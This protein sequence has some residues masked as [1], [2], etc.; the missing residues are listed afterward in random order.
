[1]KALGSEA[2]KRWEILDQDLASSQNPRA[3]LLKELHEQTRT[4]F[5]ESPGAGPERRLA[6]PEE[7][8]MDDFGQ[9]ASAP[10]QP[11]EPADFPL[12]PGEPL[13]GAE[14]NGELYGTHQDGM[15]N[16]LYPRGFGYVK[17]RA[18]VAGFKPHGFRSGMTVHDSWRWRVQH[19]QLVGVL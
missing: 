13:S 5:V 2:K 1:T 17:E 14:P 3:K 11:G 10:D 8:L 15:L 6:T 18:H 9:A 12:S 19:I 4:F 16:F 7:I